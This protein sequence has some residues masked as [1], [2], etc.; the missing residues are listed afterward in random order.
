M[1]LNSSSGAFPFAPRNL[2]Q[3]IDP[4]FWT[5]SGGQIGMINISGVASAQP[6]LEKDIIENVA[7]YGRQLGRISELLQVVLV[8]LHA[9]NWEGDEARA[10]RSFNEMM[11]KIAAVKA[12]HLAPTESNVDDLI[13]GI[14]SL[15]ETDEKEYLRMKERIREQLFPDSAARKSR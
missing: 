15:K 5:N 7:T 8:H 2:M 13:A 9:H 3:M 14:N 12:G 1:P 4:L 11:A 6:A 10:L